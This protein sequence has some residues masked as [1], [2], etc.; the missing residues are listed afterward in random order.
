MGIELPG[1]L[2]PVASLVACK[3]PECDETALKH[4]ATDW[5]NIATTLGQIRDEGDQVTKAVL[6]KISGKV[7]DAIQKYWQDIYDGLGDLITLCKAIAFACRIMAMLVLAVKL[8]IIAQL[9]ALAVQIAVDTAAAPETLGASEAEAVAAEAAAKVALKAA[10]KEL[11]E[12]IVKE[13]AISAGKGFLEGSGKELAWET[14]ETALGQRQGIN[15]SSVLHAGEHQAVQDG[16]STAANTALSGLGVKPEDNDLSSDVD[17][18]SSNAAD[19][20]TTDTPQDDKDRAKNDGGQL[21]S[22]V[23]G[24]GSNQSSSSDG[25]ATIGSAQSTDGGPSGDSGG[26]STQTSSYGGGDSGG[27]DTGGYPSGGGD[28]SGGGSLPPENVSSGPPEYP[29]DVGTGGMHHGNQDG[30]VYPTDMGTGGMH[31]GGQDGVV[32]PER[33]PALDDAPSRKSSLNLP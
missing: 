19:G 12:K 25:G 29:T 30:V 15:M 9:V 22:S 18:L 20:V 3:W 10:L 27:S 8:Y 13:T 11:L 6:G 31:H 21:L 23:F 24:G 33:V 26:D 32:T 1:P 17:S 2:K 14:A 28:S 7:H 5:D 4:V 16:V